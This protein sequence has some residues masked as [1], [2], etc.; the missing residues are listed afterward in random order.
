[1][2]VRD[3][4]IL[5]L[6]VCMCLSVMAYPNCSVM[7]CVCSIRHDQFALIHLPYV[8]CSVAVQQWGKCPSVVQT[9]CTQAM[10]HMMCVLYLCMSSSR[11]MSYESP[12]CATSFATVSRIW[13]FHVSWHL[14]LIFHSKNCLPE[15]AKQLASIPR[16]LTGGTPGENSDDDSWCVCHISHLP[17]PYGYACLS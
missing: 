7:W 15:A 9:W 1:M 12:H 10:I 11:S 8:L 4:R 13:V 17:C 2:V 3:V 5:H 16:K 14:C 6:W